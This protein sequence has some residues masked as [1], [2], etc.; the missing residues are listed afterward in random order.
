M[1][2]C[3]GIVEQARSAAGCLDFALSADT[4]EP[5]RVNVFERWES[6]ATLMAFREGGP[7]PD[8][9]EL[10]QAQVAKYRISS[11]EAP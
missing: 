9:P 1:A 4:V 7:S 2:G 3:E 10:R 6:D 5:D 11:E 8:L